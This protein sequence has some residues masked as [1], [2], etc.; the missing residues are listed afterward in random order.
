MPSMSCNIGIYHLLILHWG[1]EV[2]EPV[3]VHLNFKQMK[4][5]V[6]VGV[7]I[8]SPSECIA[9]AQCNQSLYWVF[10]KKNPHASNP[11]GLLLQGIFLLSL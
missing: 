3:S 7:N 8:V 6:V 1:I 10:R 11:V 2:R 4:F 5:F 9:P